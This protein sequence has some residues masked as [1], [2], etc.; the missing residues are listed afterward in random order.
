MSIAAIF[1]QYLAIC[2]KRYKIGLWNGNR[3]SYALCRTVTFLMI[4]SDLWRSFGWPTYCCYV[5]CGAYARAVGDS[6]VY[7][8][9]AVKWQWWGHVLSCCR[10]SHAVPREC[11][12]LLR[13]LIVQIESK[14]A[15]L[16]HDES[17]TLLDLQQSKHTIQVPYSQFG[18]IITRGQ[19][20]L[21]KSASRGAHSPVRGHPRGSKFVPL[22]SWGRGSY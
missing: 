20:N 22:N 19:S 9:T 8:C 14:E 18:I 21:T 12:S 2:G 10:P 4:L 1:D 11:H 13:D 5:V 15:E 3:K 6:W 7:C 16:R 17:D